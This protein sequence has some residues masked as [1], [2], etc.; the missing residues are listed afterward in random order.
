VQTETSRSAPDSLAGE[1]RVAG[2]DNVDL[3]APVGIALSADET[4]IWWEPRC[5]G[6]IRT[7]LISGT[8]LRVALPAGSSQTAAPG[9]PPAPVCA[10]G[11]PPRLRDVVRALDS[12]TAIERTASNG[13]LI[14]GG[15]HSLLLF[16]Q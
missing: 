10:I 12:A 4:E 8:A 14:S 11:L 7:Y 3:D 9:T 1:W 13:V 6:M 5:A 2:I 16:S 15:G